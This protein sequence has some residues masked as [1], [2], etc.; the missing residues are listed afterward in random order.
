M[1]KIL[2]FLLCISIVITTIPP[3]ALA[4]RPQSYARTFVNY[5][6]NDYGEKD[7]GGK[8]RMLLDMS[9]G[10]LLDP[11]DITRREAPVIV[12]ILPKLQ[13]EFPTDLMEIK[14]IKLDPGIGGRFTTPKISPEQL[15]ELRSRI[16]EIQKQGELLPADT[17]IKKLEA[18]ES[19][20]DG[21]KSSS[22]GK[23]GSAKFRLPPEELQ[24][25]EAVTARA[26]ELRA[27]DESFTTDEIIDML[28]Q[29]GLLT[30]DEAKRSSAGRNDIEQTG[31]V[32]LDKRRF[33]LIQIPAVIAGLS[34]WPI[35]LFNPTVARGAET[36]LSLAAQYNAG[37]ASFL[38][39]NTNT[40]AGNTLPFSFYI[41]PQDSK[42]VFKEITASYSDPLK[43]HI[44][45]RM[46]WEMTNFYDASCAQVFHVLNGTAGWSEREAQSLAKIISRGYWGQMKLWSDDRQYYRLGHQIPLIFRATAGRGQ[47]KIPD[48]F[49]GE[50]REWM[51][52]QPIEGENAWTILGLLHTHIKLHGRRAKSSL[53]IEQAERI[54][55]SILGMQ[56]ENGG[57]RHAP[58]GTWHPQGNE[59]KYND[60][61]TENNL[62]SYAALR[63]LY[64]ITGKPEYSAALKGIIKFLASVAVHDAAGE[65]YF[66][67]GAH[68]D[69]EQWR[70]KAD[71]PFATDCQTWAIDVLGVKL[72][73]QIFQRRFGI[74]DGALKMWLTTEKQAGQTNQQGELIGLSYTANQDVVSVEWTA[75]GIVA[76][77]ILSEHYKGDLTGRRLFNNAVS[78]RRYL[79]AKQIILEDGSVGYP[80]A[81]RRV[82]I[83]FGWWSP[84]SQVLSTT[85]TS[86][87]GYLNL[88]RNP[89]Y[90][91]R[92]IPGAQA[93][94]DK[95]LEDREI[96]PTKRR[97]T[98]AREERRSTPAQEPKEQV[99]A[100][101]TE[102]IAY[103]TSGTWSGGGAFSSWS[104]GPFNLS[105]Y[106]SLTIRFPGSQAGTKFYIRLLPEGA[107]PGSPI[108]LN[109]RMHTIPKNG[110]VTI[111]IS[112][113][114]ISGSQLGS[115]DQISVHSGSGAWQYRLG[116][117]ASKQ[118]IPMQIDGGL[119]AIEERPQV[120]ERE[121]RA[122]REERQQ[123]VEDS[124]ARA[125]RRERKRPEKRQPR[126][127]ETGEDIAFGVSGT[128]S[129]GGAFS[130]WWDGQFDLS[131]YKSLAIKFPQ[132]QAGTKFHIRLLPQGSSP[133]SPSGLNPRIYTVSQ[134]GV[135]TVP[136]SEFPLAGSQ[137]RSIGQ[138]SVHSGTNAWHSR[139]GQR[140][141]KQ[142]IPTGIKGLK[143]SSAGVS[144]D[145][146]NN[147]IAAALLATPRII[148]NTDTPEAL[149]EAV[150]RLTFPRS[151]PRGR[152][153]KSISTAINSAA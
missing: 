90:I 55:K 135:V 142:A 26:R 136:I 67:Q 71:E 144:V 64:E 46:V 47:W 29:E 37:I 106:K 112:E 77:L 91:D 133:G 120:K 79:E 13:I 15:E 20:D 40:I 9:R 101:K 145:L 60:Q 147:P 97:K 98:P 126:V 110:A 116:Q 130:C 32:D 134:S 143:K 81:D 99:A 56:A 88:G 127:A 36:V 117:G 49:T 125:T 122:A 16:L 31:G 83:P 54:A 8:G 53:E 24:R 52:W 152:S 121:P 21:S 85:S 6:K 141:D 103:G 2:T 149:L 111:P 39:A 38:R 19:S 65:T 132:Y 70:L 115:I 25:I 5:P 57:I 72:V 1:Y 43:A 109:P 80:Y 3:D 68:F 95:V 22:A 82:Y 62:S 10:T 104:S 42:D 148:A 119:S 73:D 100:G 61:S 48:P 124:E 45:R 102:A 78:M 129:G 14:P 63:M 41:F 28:T 23:E 131:R 137:L 75:G 108:G 150:D 44:E 113:F 33:A 76:A 94:T 139:L 96:K 151:A 58:P 84:P 93:M 140:A 74:R 89:F 153:F 138:I 30:G 118:A 123:V 11:S 146:E 4:L 87:I 114:P 50:V 59:Y 12:G 51:D 69:G 34:T 7:F 92:D 86:W 27:Q 107:S 35:S 105:R 17:V 18:L 128:W 66:A